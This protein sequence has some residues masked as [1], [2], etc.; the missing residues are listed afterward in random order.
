MAGA[1]GLS[2]CIV[3]QDIVIDS[4][5]LKQFN[6]RRMNSTNLLLHIEQKQVP[7]MYLLLSWKLR[8]SLTAHTKSKRR[9][10]LGTNLSN[11]FLT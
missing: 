6:F 3:L 8:G 1:L 11:S 2:S 10:G 5:H 7:I 9:S 4:F